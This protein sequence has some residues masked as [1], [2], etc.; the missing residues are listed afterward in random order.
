MKFETPERT[1]FPPDAARRGADAFDT[2]AAGSYRL[3]RS[4]DRL[5]PY[6]I[7]WPSE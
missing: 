3:L 7:L 2:V 4:A 6:A 1:C 5:A